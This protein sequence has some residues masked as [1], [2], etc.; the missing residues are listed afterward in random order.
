MML[1]PSL[2]GPRLVADAAP[3]DLAARIRTAHD[4]VRRSLGD[5]LRHATEAGRLL[6]EAKSA[7]GHG[8]WLPWLKENCG[9]SERTAQVYMRL[10][11]ELPGPDR[12]IRSALRI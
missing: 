9:L 7:V 10:A 4:A 5:A 2:P 12:E 11:R 6:L 1:E 3:P 8:G